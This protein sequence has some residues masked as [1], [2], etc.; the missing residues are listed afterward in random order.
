MK[1][2]LI[3]VA[4]FAI[5]AGAMAQLKISTYGNVGIG[6]NN[7]DP[8][9]KLHVLGNSYFNGNVGIGT[10]NPLTNMQIGDIWMFYDGPTNKTMARN[11][12][13]TKVNNNYDYVR[14]QQ[15]YSSQLVFSNDAIKLQ[16]AGNGAPNSIISWNT[17]T[18][19]HNGNVGIGTDNPKTTMQIGDIWTFYDGP[20][21]KIIGRNTYYNGSNYVRMQSGCASQIVFG[22]SGNISI[23]TAPSGSSGSTI[24]TWNTV[25]MLN[26]GDV[27]IGTTNPSYKLDVN[28]VL[29]VGI[30]VYPSDERL[31]TDIKPLTDEKERLYLLQGMSYKKTLLPADEEISSEDE[32]IIEF[33]EYGY[34]AQELKDVFPDLV[35]QDSLGYYSVNYIGLIPIIVEALKD[36]KRTIETRQED[37]IRQQNEIKILQDIV[38]SQEKDLNEMRN[39]IDEMRKVVI[40]CCGNADIMMQNSDVQ[41]NSNHKSGNNNTPTQFQEV[42][43]LYQNIPNPFSV[44]TEIRFEIPES[45]TS[46]KLII[47]DMQGAEIQSYTISARGTGNI[48]IQG[49]ELPA[50]MYMYTLLVNNTMIDTK[51]M[52]LT[53]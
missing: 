19:L 45:A 6:T 36:Q 28:G 43:V 30:T 32:E 40:N 50:G 48:I 12:Y 10:N 44:N 5:T 23:N 22:N 18:M 2:V 52:I 31:K 37:N 47:H 3:L 8:A 29:R 26:N 17:F 9:P 42:A 16:T 53:K 24:T 4:I 35:M 25:T 1:K 33:P 20:N 39:I 14:I 38:F 7:P 46:A 49:H 13:W 11:S 34:L 41:G 21:N 27:G 51:K 15:G